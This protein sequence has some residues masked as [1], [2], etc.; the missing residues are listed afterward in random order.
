MASQDHYTLH[1]FPF[2]LYSIMARFTH[3]LGKASLPQNAQPTDRFH[4]DLKL[5]NLHRNGNISEEYLTNINPNGQVPSMTGDK[6]PS[7]LTDSLDISYHIC[8]YYPHLLP[9]PHERLI[10]RTL[11]QLHDIQAL[12]LSVSAEDRGHT[13]PCEAVDEL[14][15]KSDISSEYRA[16]LEFKKE[17]HQ[18][19]TENALSLENVDLAETKTHELCRTLLEIYQNEGNNGN[20]LLSAP[21]VLDA[22]VVAFLGRLLDMQRRDLIP[23]ALRDW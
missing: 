5:V 2:S 4:L 3:Q 17:F 23:D 16:A 10:R 6:L 1:M 15:S 13:I 18:E 11:T 21:T 19:H 14:L 12:P 22:H 9:S 20:W 7:P 8:Q